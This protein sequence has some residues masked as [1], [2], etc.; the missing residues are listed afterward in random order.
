MSNH[1]KSLP[2]IHSSATQSRKLGYIIYPF[3]SPERIER[4]VFLIA[5]VVV[6]L[7]VFIWRAV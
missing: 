1:V 5:M 7:D 4:V 2:G 3:T 6:L